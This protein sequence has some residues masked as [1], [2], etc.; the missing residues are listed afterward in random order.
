VDLWREVGEAR[1]VDARRHEVELDLVGA[2]RLQLFHV[3]RES[4][5]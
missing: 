3:R 5:T 2:L 1:V 4:R